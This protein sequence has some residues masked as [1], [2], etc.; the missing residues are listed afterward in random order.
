MEDKNPQPSHLRF[1]MA[2]AADELQQEDEDGAGG[3]LRSYGDLVVTPGSAGPI[4]GE[5]YRFTW[6]V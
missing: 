6:G 4:H 2:V 1:T 5:E 3:R